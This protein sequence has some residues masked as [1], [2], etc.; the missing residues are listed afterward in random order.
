MTNTAELAAL[1]K[2]AE[3]DDA[4]LG[5][6]LS[7]LCDRVKAATG[8]DACTWYP[9]PASVYAVNLY[10]TIDGKVE[11]KS[12]YIKRSD[13]SA[14]VTDFDT[15]VDETVRGLSPQKTTP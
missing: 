2:K 8:A 3:G 11:R 5:V 4:A 9:M 13:L 12:R 7:T 1:V 15:L 6:W 10:S 14:K